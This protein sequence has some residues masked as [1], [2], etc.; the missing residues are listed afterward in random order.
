[1]LA[2]PLPPACLE[3]IDHLEHRIN[4]TDTRTVR[5]RVVVSRVL[6]ACVLY[7]RITIHN[8]YT[9]PREN[10]RGGT[11]ASAYTANLLLLKVA[12]GKGVGP[13]CGQEFADFVRRL[14]LF[15]ARRQSGGG[16]VKI[17][18]PFEFV[19]LSWRLN[20]KPKKKTCINIRIRSSEELSTPSPLQLA[21]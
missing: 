13:S 4:E 16:S 20:A 18:P 12:A 9:A 6:D 17:R 15:K 10:R 5:N 21:T 8:F 7:A 19:S 2:N 1:M 11:M 14:F 3:S